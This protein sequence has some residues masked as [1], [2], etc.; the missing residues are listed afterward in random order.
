MVVFGWLD[1]IGA[2][3]IGCIITGFILT[4]IKVVKTNSIIYFG[5]NLLGAL[6]LL[7]YSITIFNI[8]FIALEVIWIAVS[9]YGLL[10]M[11]RKKKML[12]L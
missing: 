9:I 10:K 7:A 3:G 11:Y 1:L 8:V 12:Q 6:F 5:I 4:G 2:T